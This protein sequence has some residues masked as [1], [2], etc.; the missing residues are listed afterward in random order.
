MAVRPCRTQSPTSNPSKA[1][2]DSPTDAPATS[3]PTVSS[4]PSL[5]PSMEPSDSQGPSDSLSKEPS[6]PS[7]TP[8]VVFRTVNMAF[9]DTH[10]VCCHRSCPPRNQQVSR[11]KFLPRYHL[12]ELL[13]HLPTFQVVFQVVFLAGRQAKSRPMHLQQH[14]VR[15][16][17]VILRPSHPGRRVHHLRHQ[18]TIQLVSN[19]QIL[20]TCRPGCPQLHLAKNLPAPHWRHQRKIQ[21]VSHQQLQATCRLNPLRQLRAKYLRV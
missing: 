4:E 8:N 16:L 13:I 9:L 11:G 19:Q 3:T 20:K 18:Q 7:E 10:L 1:P 21:L 14:R 15:N 12:P 2:S 5:H 17:P 6:S